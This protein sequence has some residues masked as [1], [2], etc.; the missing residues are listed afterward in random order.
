LNVALTPPPTDTNARAS[1]ADLPAGATGLIDRIAGVDPA[2]AAY[3]EALGV[4]SGDR[5]TVRRRGV[6]MVIEAASPGR[7]GVRIGL[8]RRLARGVLLR[9]DSIG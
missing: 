6:A 5:V 1:V 3:L 4:V 8:D 9:P 7:C 2:D